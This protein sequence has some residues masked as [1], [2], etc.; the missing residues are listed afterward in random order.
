LKREGASDAG[1][2]EEDPDSADP[3]SAVP[4]NASASAVDI[5]WDSDSASCSVYEDSFKVETVV[6]DIVIDIII[7]YI[8]KFY[9]TYFFGK[10]TFYTF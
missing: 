6:T 3:D 5:G 8:Y 4:D 10:N 2:R 7:D 1:A 9:L